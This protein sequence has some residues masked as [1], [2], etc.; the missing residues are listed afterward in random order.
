M[1]INRRQALKTAAAFAVP[2]TYRLHAAAPSETVRHASFGADGQAHSDI[3]A[4]ASHKN[5]KLVA[6]CDVDEKKLAARKEQFP[7]ANTYTD[8]RELL[9]KEKGLDSV[10][11]STPDHMH[12]PIAMSAMN[13]GLAVYCQKPLTHTLYEARRLTEAAAEKKLVT[14]MG[15]QIHSHAEHR[16]VVKLVQSGAIGKISAVHSWMGKGWGD[17]TPLPDRADEVPATF[18]WNLWL[19]VAAERPFLGNNYYHPANWRKRIDFGT[20][21]LGDMGCHILDPIFTSLGL[22]SPTAAKCSA[23][24]FRHTNWGL[25]NRVEF[26]FP[27]TKLTTDTLTLTWSDGATRAPKEVLAQLGN[28]KPGGS[29]TI[30]VGEKGIIF[31]PYI[32]MPMLLPKDLG[33]VEKVPAENH[34]HQFVD[35]VRGVGKTSA[36][37]SFAGPL[38]ETVLIGCLAERFPDQKLDWDAKN[39]KVTNLADANNLI[40]KEYRKGWEVAGL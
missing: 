15:I 1:L 7:E 12:A 8:W 38:T 28:V 10:N 14:Q 35:A 19:G 24:G 29:G 22:K 21:T 31:S 20:G 23:G 18:H 5:F 9:E 11:V 16:T 30:Y 33:T 39:L 32:D 3:N 37:F 36:P 27:G 17:P 25:D 40:R 13:R 34:Y 26:T 6:I 2:F 4:F